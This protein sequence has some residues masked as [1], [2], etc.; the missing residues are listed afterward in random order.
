MDSAVLDIAWIIPVI[1]LV[2]A[3]ILGIAGTRLDLRYSGQLAT[4]AVVSSFV[5]VCI[6][7]ATALSMPADDRIFTKVL[8]EWIPAGGFQVAAS[9]RI[10]PLTI[11][12][13]LL[14]TGVGSLI[15]IYGIGYIKGDKRATPFFS[16]MNLF[17][18]SMLILVMANDFLVLFVGWE[19]V[20]TCSYLLIGF[21]YKGLA[22][23]SAANKAFIA[24]RVGDL[25]FLIGL[26]LIFFAFGTLDFDVVFE[27]AP[28]LYGIGSGMILAICIMLTVGVTGKSAQ[29]PLYIWLP[30]AMAGPTPVSALIHA[31]TMVTAGVYLIARAYVL[32]DLAPDAR[33][34]VTAIGA[35]TTL[36]AA[37]LAMGQFRLKKVL[38][39]STI[40]QIGYMIAGVGIGGFGIV[41]GLFHLL[42]HGFFKALLFL[43]AGSI[44]KQMEDEEDMRYLGGLRKKMPITAFTY[45][46]AALA[47]SGFFP[48]SG[49]WSK[50]SVLGALF[51]SEYAWGKVMW[52][53]G[54]VAAFFTAI[55]IFRQYFMTFEGKPN[56]HPEARPKDPP[57]TMLTAL[58]VLA[59]LATFGGIIELPNVNF[60]DRWLEPVLAQANPA[61]SPER[62]NTETVSLLGLS[63]AIAI[64]GITTAYLMWRKAGA[65]AR[66]K[67]V[68]LLGSVVPFVR[69]KYYVDDVVEKVF[70]DGGGEVSSILAKQVDD[71]T[72]D[73]AVRGIAWSTLRFGDILSKVQN[74]YARLYAS[75][76]IG[77]VVLLLLY[78]I[79][80]VGV[81]G[82][83]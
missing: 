55:Y 6:M 21:W 16:Y 5:I 22:N 75:V 43:C 48:W 35:S 27:S 13:M 37:I 29:I 79:A 61:V 41:A 51:D 15:H 34:I 68:D 14:I 50:D 30:D 32:F 66:A 83:N 58:V 42:T 33:L 11:M 23:S 28:V 74:G 45:L 20:G 36:Y 53:V 46:M 67:V 24:N 39:Y 64:A 77:G 76:I 18:G 71:E 31:A 62:F 10:D 3:A 60:L 2:M 9:Y 47:L 1:P 40:S 52:A 54:I 57:K 70:V 26:M 17:I 80:R 81:G 69:H 12:M 73:G 44:M 4:A 49:F 19:L 25:G 65:P 56:W 63:F 38:A 7:F 8:Y 78:V 59:F 82:F 72:I